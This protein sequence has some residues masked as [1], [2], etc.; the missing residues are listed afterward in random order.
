MPI[1]AR[2]TISGVTSAP[3]TYL[4]APLFCRDHQVQTGIVSK[5]ENG[6]AQAHIGEGKRGAAAGGRR[7]YVYGWST[8]VGGLMAGEVHRHCVGTCN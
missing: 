6:I 1:G 5:I 4:V 8:W 3:T 7:R 2:S